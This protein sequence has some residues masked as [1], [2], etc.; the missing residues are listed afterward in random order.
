VTSTR[1]TLKFIALAT[2]VGLAGCSNLPSSPA[3]NAE[4]AVAGLNAIFTGTPSDLDQYFD[5]GF[6]RHTPHAG[7]DG[8]DELKGA[9]RSGRL[10]SAT[11]STFR[12]FF[13]GDYAVVHGRIDNLEPGVRAMTFDLFRVAGGKLAEHWDCTQPDPG[14]YAS[15]HTMSDGATV[16]DPKAGT[17]ESKDVVV[18]PGK[19]AVPEIFIKG[20]TSKLPALFDPMFIQH[21]PLAADGLAGLGAA[22]MKPP[23]DSMRFLSVHKSVGDHDFVFVRSKATLT[24]DAEKPNSPNNPTV[25]CDL[26]RVSAGKVVEHWDVIQLDPNSK[27]VGDLKPNG[28]GHTMWE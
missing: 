15:G 4:L 2:A 8:L 20:D 22:L 16:P 12:A 19:G 27:D 9:I 10:T 6:I 1:S 23:L 17:Q 18:T 25:F 11:Y 3:T 14:A 21:N 28:A 5:P 13:E 26:M 7:M 24:W